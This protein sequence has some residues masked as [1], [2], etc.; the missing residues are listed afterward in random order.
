MGAS[1]G[2]KE[3]DCRSAIGYAGLLCGEM[4]AR[5]KLCDKRFHPARSNTATSNGAVAGL[6]VRM[7]LEAL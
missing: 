5:N 2:W 3:E 6:Q 1:V 7:I 4:A